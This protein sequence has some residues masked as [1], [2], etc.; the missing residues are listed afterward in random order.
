MRACVF[1]GRAVRVDS[2]FPDPSPAAGEIRIRLRL[3]G[4]CRTDLEIVK[5]YMGFA[6]ILGHEFV[7]TA[8]EGRHEGRRV[9]GE[10]NCVCGSCDMCAAG[11]PTHCRRR[12]VLGIDGRDGAFAEYLTL[13]EAN[14]HAVPDDV[15]DRQAVFAEPLA[16]AIQ[17]GRQVNLRPGQKIVVL[18]DGRLGQLAAQVLAAWGLR[19]TVVGRAPAK[20][21]ILRSLGIGTL[22]ADQARPAKDADVVVECTGAADGLAMALAFARPRGTIILKS[23]VADTAGLNLA[24]LVVDEITVVGSRC[25]PMADA[26]AML[27]RG[28]VTV[29]PLI[30]GQYALDDA[31][32]ALAAAAQ[33]DAIKVVMRP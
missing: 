7:G 28:E 14:L 21:A 11:L 19:P 33:P 27:A 10:I 16:A 15:S 25:G 30:T 8:L 31:P 2:A 32:E 1:D 13:P 20:L 5:G 17:I 4:I 12:T 26:V 24:P 22:A 9:V 6:G 23:T 29:E 18:G 3:A